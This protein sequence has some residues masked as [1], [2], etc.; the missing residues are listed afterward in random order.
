VEFE[1][2]CPRRPNA[3]R[4]SG[5]IVR[6]DPEEFLKIVHRTEDPLVVTAGKSFLSGGYKYLTSYKGLAFFAKS[7]EVLQL[8]GDAELITAKRIWIPG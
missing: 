7:R 6:L 8:P 1:S 3:I 5:A 4:A 2:R